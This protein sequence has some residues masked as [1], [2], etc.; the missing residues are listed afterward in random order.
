MRDGKK[1]VI[2]GDVNTAHKAI[3][4]VRPKKNE[5]TSGF[6][7]MEREWI[8]QIMSMGYVDTFRQYDEG[9]SATPGGISC[10]AQ[11][12]GTWAGGLITST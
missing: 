2:C 1:L 4:L 8:D 7:P 6:L 9:P 3:D 11:E 5:K 12:S 10:Q